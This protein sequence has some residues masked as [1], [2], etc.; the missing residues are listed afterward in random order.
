MDKHNLNWN[1]TVSIHNI[2]PLPLLRPRGLTFTWWGCCGLCQRH[3]PTELA[4]P[5]HSVLMSVYVFMTLSTVFHFMHSPDN[6]PLSHSVFPVLILPYWSFQLYVSLRKSPSALIYGPFNCIS[7]PEFSWQ[8]SVFSLCFSG[9]IS[10]LLVL[11][12]KY[13]STKV[14]FS[15]DIIPS[16]WL[17]SKHQMTN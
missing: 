6:T 2:V 17:G 7:F 16:G 8:L 10:A 4:H 5:F 3:K 14:S 9:L 12:T 13:L 15:P 11:S 1:R